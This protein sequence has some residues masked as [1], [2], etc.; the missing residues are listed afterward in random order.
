MQT[1][2]RASTRGLWAMGKNGPA[3]SVKISSPVDERNQAPVIKTG[4]RLFFGSVH[5]E[6]RL[7]SGLNGSPL[8][9]L[10]DMFAEDI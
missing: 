7:R 5:T 9:P 4:K 6:L 2:E 8:P 10:K 1:E 3:P